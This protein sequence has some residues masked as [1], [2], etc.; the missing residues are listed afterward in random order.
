MCIYVCV[1]V[2]HE[3]RKGILRGSKRPIENGAYV[4][5]K[6]KGLPGYKRGI[7]CSREEVGRGLQERGMNVTKSNKHV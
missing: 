7:T 5:K 2:S 6:Q 3:T 4:I 1:F